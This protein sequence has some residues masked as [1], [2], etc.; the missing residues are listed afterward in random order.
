MFLVG[1]EVTGRGLEMGTC[2]CCIYLAEVHQVEGGDGG[3]GG[4]D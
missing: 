2:A 3:Y 4:R 1:S